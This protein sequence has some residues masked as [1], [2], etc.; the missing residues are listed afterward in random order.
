[1]KPLLALIVTGWIG[2]MALSAPSARAESGA[3]GLDDLFRLRD[4]RG[5]R[6]S[7]S[8]PNWQDGNE[9]ARRILPG[10][11]LT[12]ADLEG[13]GV[14]RHIWFT[15][16]ALDPRYG[17]SLVLRM[18]WDGQ[19]EPAVESPLGDFF[20]V[21]HGLR[22]YVDSPPVAVTSEGRAYNCYWPMPFAKRARITLTND[23][24]QH[25][26]RSVYFYVDYE[27][28]TALPPDT[29]HFHAQYRQEFPTKLGRN[30]LI[31]DTEGRGHYVGT[32]LSVYTRTAGWFGEGDDF[33]F[34]D[35]EAEPSLRGTGTED[36]FCDA[37]GFREFSRPYYGVVVQDGYELGDRVSVYRWHIPDPVRF[38]KSLKVEIE[39][40]GEMND[41]TGKKISGFHERADLFSSVAFWYQTGRARRFATLPPVEERVVPQTVVEFE[42][43]L[44]SAKAEPSA[45]AIDARRGPF[46]GD[47]DLFAKVNDP[48]TVVT[49]P[50]KL[51]TRK[52]GVARLSLGT[53]PEGGIWG[54]A[55]DGRTIDGLSAV[56]LYSPASGA[57]EIRVGMVDLAAGEHTLTLTCKGRNPAAR[58]CWLGVDALIID[59]IT[60]Y[61]VKAEKKE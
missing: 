9:D 40:K 11:T 53:A 57:R 50:F 32:V 51:E 33:F 29:A 7:S 61:V 4:G 49:I 8:D 20:A 59:E 24:K 26:V 3:P 55:L 21:G 18:Y 14:I 37:W 38:G 13:P 54:V 44:A 34:I 1:M 25:R 58:S 31:L 46:S 28:V 17:R 23:S 30:Y 15:I 5:M 60:P 39:H 36:Y 16:S 2:W 48:N 47:Q 19:E 43:L 10:E 22:R 27:K 42:E 45:A 35:G 12:I 6:A 41:E 56:D 52:Q